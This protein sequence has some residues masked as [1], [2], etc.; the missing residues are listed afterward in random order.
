M[1]PVMLPTRA[2]GRVQLSGCGD[3]VDEKQRAQEMAERV[4][5]VIAVDNVLS[6][7]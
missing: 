4:D 7:K 6:V 1:R 3:S 5:G 2:K